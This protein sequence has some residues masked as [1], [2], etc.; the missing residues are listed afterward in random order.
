[1]LNKESQRKLANLLIALEQGESHIEVL[2]QRLCKHPDFVV[3]SV[4]Q[5]ID[6]EK[7]Q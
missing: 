1:M 4:F 6:K 5:M 2:R 7:T 3:Q